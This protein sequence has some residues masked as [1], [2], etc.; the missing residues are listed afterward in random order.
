VSTDEPTAVAP[1]RRDVLERIVQKRQLGT[2]QRHIFLCVG[3]SCA[4][5][6]NQ[7]ASWEFL[8][9]RLKELGLVDAPNGV[10]RTKADC[11]RICTG[12]PVALVYPEGTWYRNCTPENLERIIQGHLIAG[13]PVTDLVFAS[14]PL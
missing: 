2:Q 9:H 11:L 14:N 3:G 4:P 6:E 8:K 7:Q 13:Q 5:Q 1:D 12:G 10:L